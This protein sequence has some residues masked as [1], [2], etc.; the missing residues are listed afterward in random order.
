MDWKVYLLRCADNSLYCGITND[1]S[2]RIE[3]HNTGKGA[4][5]T[6]SRLPVALAAVSRG[7]SKSAALRLEGSIKRQPAGKKIERLLQGDQQG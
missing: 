2:G 4:K 7:M 3:K 6:Q 5:Y 1:L